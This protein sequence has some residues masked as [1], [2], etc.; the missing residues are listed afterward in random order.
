MTL[1]FRSTSDADFTAAMHAAVAS[2]GPDHISPACI[3]FD[4]I[5]DD[6][7]VC[8][9]GTA[10]SLLGFTSL[11]VPEGEGASQV[12][13]PLGF[14]RSVTYAAQQAQSFQDCKLPWSQ[15]LQAYTITLTGKA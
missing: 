14:S 2:R 5:N 6:V 12:L 7:P 8:L 13:G 4:A 11:D 9:I 15:A 1:P 3:Y 10:L